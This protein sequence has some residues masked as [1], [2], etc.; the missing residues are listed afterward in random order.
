MRTRRAFLPERV[1]SGHRA[2]SHRRPRRNDRAAVLSRIVLGMAR[3]PRIGARNAPPPPTSS[4]QIGQPMTASSSRAVEIGP[5]GR[6]ATYRFAF[7]D[8]TLRS[9]AALRAGA[10]PLRDVPAAFLRV[11]AAFFATPRLGVPTASLSG[12]PAM[13]LRTRFALDVS[14]ELLEEWIRLALL[15]RTIDESKSPRLAD[16]SKKVRSGDSRLHPGRSIAEAVVV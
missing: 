1:P 6:S 2:A 4:T 5:S 8:D 9:D 15:H 3:R 11:G 10:A 13:N 7:P 12:L 16:W 14:F